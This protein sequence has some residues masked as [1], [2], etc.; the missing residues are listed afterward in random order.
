A[1]N[2]DLLW[3]GLV[4][5]RLCCVVSDHSP[6]TPELKKGDF[7]TAWGG[8]SSVQLGLPAVWTEARRRGVALAEVVRWMAQ[9]P[10]E[11]V[12]LA[13]KGRIEIGRDGDL[14]AFA[15]EDTFVVDGAALYH[16]HPLTPYS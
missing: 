9:G 14:V 16:R 3:D 13:G 11:L 5:G 15:A 1:A 10:A 4:G 2:R 7:A 6:C 12:G 8:I